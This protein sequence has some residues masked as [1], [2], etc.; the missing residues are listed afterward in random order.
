MNLYLKIFLAVVIA[1]GVG[2]LLW[3]LRGV[4]LTPISLG[5]N[6]TL[7]LI[8]QVTGPS[9]ALE[10]SVNALLWLMAD[11]VLRAELVI[12]DGGM[13]EET[14]RTAELL[15]RDNRRVSLWTKE[16]SSN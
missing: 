14:R 9:P 2:V 15:A 6:E 1:G 5:K 8:L 16:S 10:N 7:R 11:G 3:L 12:E 13:D 4:L